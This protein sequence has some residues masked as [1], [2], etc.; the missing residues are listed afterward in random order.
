MLIFYKCVKYGTHFI[1]LLLII[2]YMFTLKYIYL[3][4]PSSNSPNLPP[5]YLPPNLMH[6]LVKGRQK[7]FEM[8]SLTTLPTQISCGICTISCL[9]FKKNVMYS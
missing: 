2:L 3:P 6:F 9:I 4:F 7:C 8:L 5:K 1:S